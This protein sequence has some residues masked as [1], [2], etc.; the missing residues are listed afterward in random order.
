MH[1]DSIDVVIRQRASEFGGD[2]VELLAFRAVPSEEAAFEPGETSDALREFVFRNGG[3]RF[4]FEERRHWTDAG[5]SGS[6][7][8]YVL[9]LLGS[10]AVGVALSEIYRYAR[11]R[12]RGM[13]DETW[14][15]EA[16]ASMTVEDLRD[17][18]LGDAERF[19]EV[20]RGT[21]KAVDIDRTNE[22]AVMTCR[23]TR[24]GTQHHAESGTDGAF[25]L[26]ML[27]GPN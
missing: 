23:D 16:F 7:V 11:E 2:I 26:R 15:A 14:R 12:F 20:P 1:P 27:D 19:L 10:G 8:V 22:R 13:G 25:V 3:T 21:I 4:T 24:T 9:D 18:M 5:A 6:G 17:Q